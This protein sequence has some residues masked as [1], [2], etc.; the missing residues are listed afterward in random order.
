MRTLIVMPHFF[1]ASV[2]VATNRSTQ[3]GAHDERLRALIAAISSLHQALGG[4]TYGLDHGERTAW[5]MSPAAPHALDIVIVT[6]GQSHL[7][8]ELA[9]LQRMLRHHS[10]DADPLMLGFECHKLMRDSYGRYDYYGYVEDD[11]VIT[12]PLFLR[13]RRLFDE[14]F[15]PYALLQPNR[16]EAS[17]IPPVTKLYVD[18]RLAAH[19]TA[20]Y[21][22]IADQPRL[23]LSFL[24]DVIAYERTSYPSSG[25][26]FLSD[27][28]LGIWIESP[29]FLDSDISYLSPLDSAVTLSVMKTFRIYKPVLDQAWFLEVLHA[30]PRWIGSVTQIAKLAAQPPAPGIP[31][32]GK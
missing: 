27:N 10:T 12:D 6:T 17:P 11:I 23:E 21:Q 14:K 26:F 25:C 19:V 1:K 32:T 9:P 4:S 22:D 15:G 16:Y 31:S 20:P 29:H 24:D 2:Q 8:D 5:H 3:I 18:Y 7:V 30:S 28:Q 13:K